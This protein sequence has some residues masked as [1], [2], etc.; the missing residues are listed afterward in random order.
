MIK[1]LKKT[2]KLNS[3][4]ATV[5]CASPKPGQGG[6]SFEICDCNVFLLLRTYMANLSSCFVVYRKTVTSS[7]YSLKVLTAVQSILTN[8]QLCETFASNSKMLITYSIP[9]DL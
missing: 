9:T 4:T 5:R 8:K 3:A 1:K 2:K 7:F 6:G